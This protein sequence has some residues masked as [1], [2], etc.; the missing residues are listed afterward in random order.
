MSKNS[1]D[2]EEDEGRISFKIS[3]T[4]FHIE[5]SL[6]NFF[7]DSSSIVDITKILFL[8]NKHRKGKKKVGKEENHITLF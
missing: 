1:L 7:L 5:L 6:H 3:R 2:K 8:K 4:F